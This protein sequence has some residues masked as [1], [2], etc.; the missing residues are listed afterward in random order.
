MNLVAVLGLCISLGCS[1]GGGQVESVPPQ[2]DW[3][4]AGAVP[5]L[6]PAKPEGGG[7]DPKADDE[8]DRPPDA[9]H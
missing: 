2:I 3:P 5:D 4:D 7:A 1:G 8:S 6:S 9:G